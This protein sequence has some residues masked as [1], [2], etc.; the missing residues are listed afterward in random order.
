[1][2]KP[3]IVFA[4][5]TMSLFLF[6]CGSVNQENAAK[7]VIRQYKTS[8]YNIEDYNKAYQN[9]NASNM[10]EFL[11]SLESYKKYF[12]QK[13]YNQF[14]SS[15]AAL[16]SIQACGEGKHNLKVT[17]IIFDKISV[18]NKDKLIIDYRVQL[19]ADYQSGE[20][21]ADEKS[22]ATLVKENNV[23]KISNDWFYV[24]DLFRSDLNFP[25]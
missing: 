13:G 12:T 7:E 17:N 1:M 25:G 8:L 2:R 10:Q 5:L 22:Q 24:N 16:I 14:M 4:L 11:K 21:V 15:R 19:K 20:K 18:E 9:S 3:L 23:W 6:G